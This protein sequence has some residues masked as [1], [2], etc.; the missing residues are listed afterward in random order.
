MPGQDRGNADIDL[1]VMRV[2]LRQR[3]P[4]RARA[5][6]I[7]PANVGDKSPEEVVQMFFPERG[8]STAPARRICA[9][10]PV[11]AECTAGNPDSDYGMW[12]GKMRQPNGR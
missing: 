8:G 7:D 2:L 9:R 10:C 1:E 5:A 6:C 11:S 4:W 3:E 12:G